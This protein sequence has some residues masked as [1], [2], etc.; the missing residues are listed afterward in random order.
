MHEG[1]SADGLLVR[2]GMAR[3]RRARVGRRDRDRRSTSRVGERPRVGPPP[4]AERRAGVDDPGLRER[5]LPRVPPRA[6]RPHPRPAGLVLDLARGRCTRSPRGS[7]RTRTTTLARAT[8]AEMALAGITTVGE[9]H[10]VHHGRAAAVRRPERDGR[11]PGRRRRRD[12]GMRLTLLDAC[13]LDGGIGRRSRAA[14]AVRRRRRGRLGRAR[15]A[16]PPTTDECGSGRRS[17]ACGRCP[18]TDRRGRRVGGRAGRPLHAH[19]SE[20]PAENE[21]CLAAYGGTPDPAARRRGALGD[22]VHRRARDAPRPTTTSRCSAA[23]A[24]AAS[25]RPPSATSPTASAPAARSSTPAPDSRSAPTRHAVID[26]VRGGARRRARRAA[27]TP[28]AG[29]LPP[30]TSRRGDRGRPP[31]ASAGRRR[32]SSGALA[33]LATVALDRPALGRARRPTALDG[34][35]RGDRRRRAAVM[36]GGTRRARRRAHPLDVARPTGRPIERAGCAPMTA[37]SID[38]IGAARHERPRRWATVRSG[39]CRD[40][41]LVIDGRRASPR[42]S[43]AGAAADE[44]IDAGGPLRHPRLCRQ[45]HP[46]RLRRR[47][48]GRVRRP[49]G[50]ARRT[51]AGGIRDHG[52]RP[53]APRPTTS[54]ARCRRAGPRRC[55]PGI[56]TRRDQVRLRPDVA[57]RGAAAAQ[58]AGEFTDEMTF[59]GAHV[60]PPEFDGPR[61][62]LRRPRL[63]RML[64]ACAPHA[65]WIDVF[66][67]QG[68]FDADQCR[69]VL[70]AGAT[71]GL[72]MRVHGNQLGQGPG[73]QLAVELGAASVDHC[74]Y[75]DRCRRRRPG[76]R[77]HGRHLPAG[78]RLLDRAPYPDGRRVIDAGAPRNRHE[79]QPGSSYTTSMPF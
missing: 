70:E 53:R 59:L 42:S 21:A 40:A 72:G 69:A 36:V 27:R 75:L 34:R 47:P 18:P 76:R 66:C 7:T 9:F 31:R 33:D 68:A 38:R 63:R 55:A 6:A 52:R 45:P 2:A 67:E 35:V 61:R 37:S 3:R 13:Y 11:R 58:V 49:D 26:L 4:D 65:R 1:G 22:A 46:S 5:P 56:T 15:R 39:S 43:V 44:R 10:Y 20:Q 64:D 71:A 41:A 25:A 78:G 23:S 74:T 12:A 60:V 73:V 30:P 32:A 24:G 19:V 16:L 48:L 8:Y 29:G 79:L 14:A 54:C 57:R 62:R 77:R 50:R 17:T 51:T 28:S